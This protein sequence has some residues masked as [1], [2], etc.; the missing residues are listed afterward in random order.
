MRLT[1]VNSVSSE[2]CWLVSSPSSHFGESMC[3]SPFRGAAVCPG[4]RMPGFV[5][6]LREWPNLDQNVPVARHSG[7]NRCCRLSAVLCLHRCKNLDPH[8]PVTPC[9][10]AFPKCLPHLCLSWLT[11]LE[12]WMEGSVEAFCWLRDFSLASL[13]KQGLWRHFSLLVYNAHRWRAESAVLRRKHG[14]GNLAISLFKPGITEEETVRNTRKSR[15]EKSKRSNTQWQDPSSGTLAVPRNRKAS[16]GRLCVTPCLTGD[17][18]ANR[19]AR[20]CGELDW[21]WSPAPGGLG[22][23][24]GISSPMQNPWG[25]FTVGSS[26]VLFCSQ[27]KNPLVLWSGSWLFYISG[28]FETGSCSVT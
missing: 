17:H 24:S 6:D 9:L 21:T 5:A 13:G 4:S 12:S 16:S 26:G 10:V 22:F 25:H 18:R 11:A 20:C 2:G 8:L 23:D 14:P 15:G 28:I 3:F 1:L 27:G 19:L 7:Q